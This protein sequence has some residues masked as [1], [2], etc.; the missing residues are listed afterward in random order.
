M[1]VVSTRTLS[2]IRKSAPLRALTIRQPD[3]SL[4]IA[5]VLTLA[6]RPTAAPHWATRRRIVIHAASVP[7]SFDELFDTGDEIHHGIKAG[8]AT[9]DAPRALDLLKRHWHDPT[10]FPTRAGLGTAYLGM[11]RCA[12]EALDIPAARSFVNPEWFAWPLR[13]PE[14]FPTPVAIT[15]EPGFWRW[16]GAAE[17]A[18]RERQLPLA[19]AANWQRA[20]RP[21]RR[22]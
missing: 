2:D 8:I 7:L 11:P 21:R 15:G 6:L 17:L 5:G 14:P 3:A 22:A 10:A 1:T 9:A 4:I 19:L 18:A 12:R 20:D 16:P 13:D